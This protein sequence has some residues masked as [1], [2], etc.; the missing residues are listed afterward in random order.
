MADDMAAL[1]L[2]LGYE[3]AHVI[4]HSNGG[5]VALVTLLEHPEVVQT[6]I[7]EAANAY[8]SPDLLEREPPL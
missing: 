4:G 3:R 8:V 2:A 1:I 7:P 6:V 5:N